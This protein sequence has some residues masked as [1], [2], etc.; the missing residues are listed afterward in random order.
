MVW[1]AE[2]PQGAEA[3]KCK[4]DLVPYV[5]NGGLDLGCGAWKVF[6]HFIGVD[7]GKDTELFGVQMRP[8]IVVKTCERLPLFADGH[9]ENVFSSHLLEHI[10]DYKAALKEWWRL[11]AP[12]G[13]LILYL[14][15]R[16]LY[17]NIG[18]PGANPDHKH[19]FVEQDIIDAMR[20]VATGW[21]LV[22]NEK[23][24]MMREYSFLQVYKKL[25]MPAAN[26]VP[27]PVSAIDE[28]L[29]HR[30]SWKN[31][32]A[33][34]R[35]AIVRPGAIGD[36]I[37]SSSLAKQFKEE[38]F[39]VTLYTGPVG[40][41]VMRH[42]P[43]IDRII[44]IRG[45]LMEDDTEWCLYY[46]WEAKKYDRFVNLIGTIESMLLPHPN[47][48]P[49][50]WPQSVRH[51]RMNRNYQEVMHE[52]AQLNP[53]R[54]H[55]VFSPTQ[56]EAAW[57]L[58]Q[59]RTLFGG[60][61]LVVVSPTGSGAPKTWPHVQRFMEIMAVHEVHTLVL[62]EIRQEF[63][64]PVGWGHILGKE[65][66]MRL[67][68][69]LALAAD[70]VVGTESAIVNAVASAPM[71][72]VVLLSHSTPENLTKHWVNTMSVE[73]VG[74]GCYPCHRLHRGF[75]FCTQDPVTKWAACQS[76]ATAEA[77]AEPVLGWLEKKGIANRV[78]AQMAANVMEAAA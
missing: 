2:D 15:H 16:D 37:W 1:N 30:E 45:D 35:A 18:Q 49:Y 78:N 5:G 3:H 39:E 19:D 22:V 20:E 6:P 24:D 66:N 28:L 69:T 26:A 54:F 56:K 74:L 52:Q 44:T 4:Y 70:V 43:N 63:D 48:L 64:P 11:V 53:P 36:A 59:R 9:A 68:M 60:K 13:H 42:D 46:L 77:I 76:K 8:E 31:P 57:A 33:P 17:P 27:D 62:G 10:E 55:Q 65:L 38:G 51:A 40:E 73:P 50:F 61:P 72:K 21:D 7:S 32:R 67:A 29:G 75:E 41:E 71:L 47:E 58:E 34:K 12:G 25:E 14:P 23:R